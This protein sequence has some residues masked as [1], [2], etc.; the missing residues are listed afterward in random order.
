MP[1]EK[2][3]FR[4]VL[5]RIYEKTGGKEMLSQKDVREFT[6]LSRNTV[7]KYITFNSFGFV[8]A[9]DLARQLLK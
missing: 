7:K 2:E 9:A 6:G 4:D 8:A 3:S 5:E 1:R